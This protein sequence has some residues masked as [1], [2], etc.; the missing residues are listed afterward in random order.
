VTV[1]KMDVMTVVKQ[2][3]S[4]SSMTVQYDC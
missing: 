2:V 1:S 3:Q 4:K